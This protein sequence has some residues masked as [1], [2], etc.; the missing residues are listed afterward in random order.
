MSAPA[1]GSAPTSVPS[2]LPRRICIG[3]FFVSRHMPREDVV[4]RLVDDHAAAGRC[5]TAK[6]RISDTANMPIISGI[7]ADAA[8]QLGAA[9]GEAR[10][11]RRIVEPDARD[12]QAEQ[13]R[14]D[15]L[16]RPLG[17]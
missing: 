4:D 6:R 16:Q 15:A 5:R 11:A 14:H 13:Q 7:S 2:A 1:P 10:E 9:E 17:R 8:H 3:Y 12:Q